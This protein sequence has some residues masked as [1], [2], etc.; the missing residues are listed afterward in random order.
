DGYANW[1]RALFGLNRYQEAIP[2]LESA[3]KISPDD[4]A[5][6]TILAISY[7]KTGD[8]DK[9]RAALG[10]ALNLN[11][12]P[13][14]LNNI[15][16]E[17]AE[18]NFD[19][20]RAKDCAEKAVR[21]EEEAS[22][23]VE[24]SGLQSSAVGYTSRLSAYWDTLG[25]VY[26]KM[27]DLLQAEKYLLAAWQ[28]SQ[29]PE[30]ADHLG[31]LYEKQGKN[32]AALHMYQLAHSATPLR[33]S[34]GG[35]AQPKDEADF[36]RALK[37]LGGKPDPGAAVTELNKMRSFQLPRIVRG[38]AS[39]QFFVLLGPG[40]KVEAKFISGADSLKGVE[41]TVTK[42]NYKFTFPDSAP[43]RVA[44]TATLGCYPYSGCSI[45]FIMP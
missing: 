44:Y 38:T 24:L 26:F 37:R 1:G 31:K 6:V 5:L 11:P 9:S 2:P 33:T 45:V 12:V 40:K 7:M 19:L 15:A 35:A 25:W 8:V 21:E 18:Q 42:A 3:I 43:S 16:Y 20:E 34:R 4:A 28:F 41:S 30:S 39:A 10:K 36:D 29:D 13:P 22:G 17:L 32:R 23:K 27:N 14:L